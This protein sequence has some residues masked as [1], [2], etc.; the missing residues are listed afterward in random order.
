MKKK[1]VRCT[2]VKRLVQRQIQL[3][4]FMGLICDETIDLLTSKV[5]VLYTKVVVNDCV[6]TYF[7]GVSE[8]ADGTAET[9]M[10]SIKMIAVYGV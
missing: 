1:K 6:Q 7:L 3:S 10:E 9:V 4:P 5:L 8:L 2:D